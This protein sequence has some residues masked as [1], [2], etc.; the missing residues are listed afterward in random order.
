MYSNAQKLSAVIAKWLEPAV[1]QIGMERIMAIPALNA[2]QNKVRS[3][4]WVGPNWSMAKEL[5][6]FLSKVGS[7]VMEPVIQ[8]MI[9]GYPDKELP[10]IAH[11]IVDTAIE[12]G[13]IKLF[14]GNVTFNE[15][16]LQVLKRLLDINLPMEEADEYVVK[17]D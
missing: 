15:D 2:I 4:G 8:S 6:P 17:T 1:E 7:K 5:S 9:S 10:A 14:E 16:D 12:Q 3:T 13:E 11:R